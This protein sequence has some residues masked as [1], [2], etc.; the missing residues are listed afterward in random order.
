MTDVVS[1]NS[2]ASATFTSRMPAASRAGRQPVKINWNPATN[3]TTQSSGRSCASATRG[4]IQAIRYSS[5]VTAAA[6]PSQ[7]RSRIS[8]I[9]MTAASSRISLIQAGVRCSS[10]LPGW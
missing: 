10:E 9:S 7:R 8:E 3:G 4:G 5:T 6:P 1:V 2:A